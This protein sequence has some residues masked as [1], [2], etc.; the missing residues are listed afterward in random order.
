MKA[1]IDKF[2]DIHF[3]KFGK[4]AVGEG[5][6]S[7]DMAW[8]YRPKDGKTAA[9]YKDYRRFVVEKSEN[10]T[11]SLVS[12]GEYHSGLN[13]RKRKRNQKPGLRRVMV[14]REMISLCLSLVKL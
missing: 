11:L 2:K 3:Y 7:C 6:N 9:F 13:A 1:T 4:P 10:C 12:I 8:R 14:G 5:V